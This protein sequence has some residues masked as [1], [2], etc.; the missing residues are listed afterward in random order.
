MCFS[1]VLH[2]CLKCFPIPQKITQENDKNTIC[3][4]AANDTTDRPT[5]RPT[6]K[7]LARWLRHENPPLQFWTHNLQNNQRSEAAGR[8]MFSVRRET[9]YLAHYISRN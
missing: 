1:F 3:D 4:E 2:E 7:E 9:G 5:D 8:S 6:F